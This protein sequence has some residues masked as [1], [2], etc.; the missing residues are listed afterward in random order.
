MSISEQ[1]GVELRPYQLESCYE[2]R[3]SLLQ[4]FGFSFFFGSYLAGPL[5]SFTR[6]L[7]LADGSLV[8][9]NTG[10]MSR[11]VAAC[12]K[13]LAAVLTFLFYSY[14]VPKYPCDYF[15]TKVSLCIFVRLIWRWI[16][17]FLSTS[18]FSSNFGINRSPFFVVL[19][20]WKILRTMNLVSYFVFYCTGV[21]WGIVHGEDDNDDDDVPCQFLQ[22]RFHMDVCWGCDNHQ[23]AWLQRY[24]HHQQWGGWIWSC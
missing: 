9:E 14:Y 10:H 15:L 5:F 20:W 13:F 1:S 2:E 24:L 11:V 22:V 12:H 17:I 6:Y 7:S 3:P 23:R 4:M 18:K 8:P 19:G 16:L 21:F